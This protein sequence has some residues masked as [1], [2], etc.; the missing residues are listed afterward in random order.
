MLESKIIN[1]QKKWNAEWIWVKDAPNPSKNTYALFRKEFITNKNQ[2]CR[3]NITADSRYKVFIDGKPVGWGPPQSQPYYHY[4]DQYEVDLTEGEHCLAVIVYTVGTYYG[5]LFMELTGED[6]KCIIASGKDWQSIIAKAWQQDTFC[7]KMNSLTPY[8]EIFDSTMFPDN[9]DKAG[10]IDDHWPESVI[11]R[12]HYSFE[13]NDDSYWPL[14]VPRDIDYLTESVVY[15]ES[16]EKVEEALWLEPRTRNDLSIA[17]SAPG[18]PLTTA[19][20]SGEENLTSDTGK[21]IVRCSVDHLNGFSDG[22]YEPVILLDF[23]RIIN[24]FPEII[25]DAP[26]GTRVQI[27]YSERLIDGYFNNAIEGSFADMVILK[28]GEQPW[29]PAL[30]RSFRYLI[31]R[32]SRC[33]EQAEIHNIRAIKLDY[34]YQDRGGFISDNTSLNEVFDISKETLKLCSIDCLTDTPWRE[35]AQWLGDVA[36]VTTPAIHACF[37]ETKLTSKFF[38]QSGNNQ[39]ANGFLSNMSNKQAGDWY[40]NIPDY[41]L[42]WIMSLWQQYLYTGNEEWIVYFYPECLRIVKAHL[43]YLNDDGLIENIPY[44]TLIDWAPVDKRG[45]S[46]AY[47]AV[48][49]G[50]LRDIVKMCEFMGDHRSCRI[51]RQ[52]LSQIRSVYQKTFFAPEKQ[53]VVDSIIAGSPTDRYSEHANFSAILWNLCDD[54]TAQAIIDN[55]YVNGNDL[56]YVEAQPFYMTVILKALKKAGRCDLAIKLITE[57]WGER[58][59]KRGLKSCS[60]EWG[61]NGS[62]RSGSYSGFMRT[63]SHAWSACPAE[64]LISGLIGLEIVKPGGTEISLSPYEGDFD[65][66]ATYPLAAGKVTVEYKDR[67]LNT[68]TTGD[69]SIVNATP[70]GNS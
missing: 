56:K 58:M 67:Q 49:C 10:G 24:A 4:Y 40:R 45:L 53:L 55:F 23:G 66:T 19:M 13:F 39:M 26:A 30:W 25:I 31:V 11:L 38:K 6:D 27:G 7:F 52:I 60:E 62:W 22:V 57:R 54:Q 41:S 50:A 15:P 48:F 5:G 42:W 3:L 36:A 32:I 29:R 28:G 34:P 65:Y 70:S 9:W 8:Q 21:T 14:L 2:Q 1:R 44:F 69:T 43:P 18:R 59:V 68:Q 37:G 64:F 51:Y 33:Y 46:S 20:V 61:E 17:L 12:G 63:R 35:A 16:I 47:N